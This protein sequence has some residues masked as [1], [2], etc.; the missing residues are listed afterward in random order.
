MKTK[1]KWSSAEYTTK[2]CTDR[3]AF[4]DFIDG[5]TEFHIDKTTLNNQLKGGWWLA[6]QKNISF[7]RYFDD[8]IVFDIP[9][10]IKPNKKDEKTKLQNGKYLTEFCNHLIGAKYKDG[11]IVDNGMT[12]TAEGEFSNQK[13]CC[14]SDIPLLS[15]LNLINWVDVKHPD[16]DIASEL[17]H[18]VEH[19][20]GFLSTAFDSTTGT[21]LDK[22]DGYHGPFLASVQA[23]FSNKEASFLTI[24]EKPNGADCELELQPYDPA[25]DNYALELSLA[26][27]RTRSNVVGYFS[28]RLLDM[29]G[30]SDRRL[31]P[32][33]TVDFEQPSAIIMIDR[34]KDKAEAVAVATLISAGCYV[35]Q[36]EEYDY[37]I[38][39][40]LCRYGVQPLVSARI[41]EDG[42]VKGYLVKKFFPYAFSSYC[43]FFAETLAKAF[44]FKRELTDANHLS[45]LKGDNDREYYYLSC[46]H[47][48]I[49]PYES[50]ASASAFVIGSYFADSVGGFHVTA[51]LLASNTGITWSIEQW[52]STYDVPDLGAI[53]DVYG[54]DPDDL[55]D[56]IEKGLD[57]LE[58]DVQK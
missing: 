12:V 40:S 23:R 47:G 20:K 43:G 39:R 11:K 53:A 44:G 26:I 35:Y 56:V 55:E 4:E 7:K 9:G 34:I 36:M 33:S 57:K 24:D 31:I 28:S 21:R 13:F 17:D 16:E 37:H 18:Y 25:I 19:N 50:I 8:A 45:N 38:H 29:L 3:A 48:L 15:C 54:M 27:L 51:N 58:E 6:K 2:I 22:I 1:N 14:I 42:F 10:S 32:L 46:Q 49:V 41:V 30:A 5:K 52:M